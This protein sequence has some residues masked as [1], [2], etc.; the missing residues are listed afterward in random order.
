MLDTL[1]DKYTLFLLILIRMSGAILINPI[2]GRRNIPNNIKIGL[3]LMMAVTLTASSTVPVPEFTGIIEFA[4]KGILEFMIGFVISIVMNV[5]FSSIMTAAD[6]IDMQLGIGM[7]KV[8][9]PGS[10]SSVPVTGSFY[11]AFLIM[12]FFSTNGHI[13]LFKLLGDTITAL[14]CGGNL[15]IEGAFSAVAGIFGSSLTLAVKFAFPIIAIEFIA[16][17]GL[18]VL[19]RTVPN[20][21]VFSVGIQLKL[22]IG[23][24]VMLLLSP[25]FGLFCDELYNKMFTGITGILRMMGAG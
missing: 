6:L 18:G 4:L 13:T 20:I 21:N 25:I 22:F 9:D 10:S 14:P 23:L 15:S 17:T 2:F 11:N 24:L 1:F 12:L 7:S 5:F 16:E 8:F 3:T 19:T